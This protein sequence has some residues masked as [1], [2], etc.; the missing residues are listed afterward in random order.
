MERT[1]Q[2]MVKEDSFKN[3]T[4]MKRLASAPLDGKK[5]MC[6]CHENKDMQIA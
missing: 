3:V 6:M 4:T 2:S 1:G 5:D